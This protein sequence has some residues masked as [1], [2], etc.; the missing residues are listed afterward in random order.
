MISAVAVSSIALTY[1][2]ADWNVF[3]STNLATAGNL[4][5]NWNDITSQIGA[6][7]ATAI[8]SC[9]SE[10]TALKSSSSI[11]Y[12]VNV[13]SGSDTNNGT[14]AGAAFASIQTAINK[15]PQMLNHS[16]T[17]YCATGNYNEAILMYGFVGSG[18]IWLQGGS[19][20]V[21]A[22]GYNTERVAAKQNGILVN[23]AG[24]NATSTAFSGF[25]NVNSRKVNFLYCSVLTTGSVD[26][27]TGE[28][29]NTEVSGCDVSN[30]T[31]GILATK[32]GI[33]FSSNNTGTSNTYGLYARYAG[34]IGINGT[35]PAGTTT[36]LATAGG[37]IVT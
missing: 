12:Y 23:V 2:T 22:T 16:A 7:Y 14:S 17:I 5:A 37:Q 36:S 24:L 8:N 26:G 20:L 31:F 4:Q 35:Y 27:F 19:S 15:L 11:A 28:G 1:L 32:G 29:G 6:N 33:I 10:L 34:K 3:N 25:G 9:I 21:S 30:R 13:A 18:Q